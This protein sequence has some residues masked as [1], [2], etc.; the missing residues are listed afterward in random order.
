[1]WKWK[2]IKFR[3]YSP[4]RTAHC[5]VE[6]AYSVLEGS[7]KQLVQLVQLADNVVGGCLFSCPI[8]TVW[9]N[10]ELKR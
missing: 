8:T 6:E 10:E 7:T 2:V 9:G 1:M 5:R 4:T 3:K